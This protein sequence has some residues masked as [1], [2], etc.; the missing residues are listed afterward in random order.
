MDEEHLGQAGIKGNVIGSKPEETE[1]AG[2][3]GRGEDQVSDG[4]HAE[5]EEHRLVETSLGPHHHQDGHIPHHGHHVHGA[6]GNPNPD[7][8]VL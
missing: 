6:E 1:H 8:Q 3:R 7:M 2:Q 5:E 4:E